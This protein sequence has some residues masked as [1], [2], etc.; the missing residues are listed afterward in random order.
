MG[1]RL[2]GLGFGVTGLRVWGFGFGVQGSRSEQG[3]WLL[4]PTQRIGFPGFEC[5]TW[6]FRL[7]TVWA[8]R[9]LGFRT[10]QTK[11]CR[12]PQALKIHVGSGQ[13]SK[14]GSLLGSFL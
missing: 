8:L 2:W 1:F 13:F 14:I 4:G 10:T 9:V 6:A 7:R 11:V 5:R 3:L 12:G